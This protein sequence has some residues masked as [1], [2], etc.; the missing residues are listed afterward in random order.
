VQK[1]TSFSTQNW[2]STKGITPPTLPVF[3]SAKEMFSSM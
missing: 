2:G 1:R 3:E